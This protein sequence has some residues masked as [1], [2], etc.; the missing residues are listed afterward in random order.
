MGIGQKERENDSS[1]GSFL[2]DYLNVCRVALISFDLSFY[3]T[4]LCPVI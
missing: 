1:G 4:V 3:L 2:L